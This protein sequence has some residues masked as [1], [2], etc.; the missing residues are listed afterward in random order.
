MPA[1]H[2]L[3]ALFEGLQLGLHASQ[4]AFDDDEPLA[5][6]VGRVDG[7]LVFVLDGLF[8]IH[9][10]ERVE[11]VFGPG[12]RIVLQREGE[13]GRFFL[14][15][16]DAQC[17]FV[18]VHHRFHGAFHDPYGSAHPGI[19]AVVGGSGHHAHAFGKGHRVVQADGVGGFRFNPGKVGQHDGLLVFQGCREGEALFGQRVRKAEQHGRFRVKLVGAQS[20]FDPVAH[21]GMDAL[22]HL[23]HELLGTELEDFVGHVHLI[24]NI[25]ETV[26]PGR[27]RLVR[28][29]FDDDGGRAEIDQRRTGIVVPCNAPAHQD[30]KQEPLP[31]GCEENEQVYQVDALVVLL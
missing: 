25:V 9:I 10:N 28:R 27:G 17:V 18:V 3:V 5:D 13:D 15:L 20:V 19:V 12:G 16:L 2:N 1:V 24:N 26:Q 29:V 30:G 4:L 6:E 11:H 31:F 22:H 7:H 21:V 23:A 14:F 8:V